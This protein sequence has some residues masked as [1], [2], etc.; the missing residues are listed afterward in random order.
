[1][2]LSV[3]VF[4]GIIIINSEIVIVITR[5]IGIARFVQYV[6]DPDGQVSTDRVGFQEVCALLPDGHS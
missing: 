2:L 4:A 3:G 1:M 5:A 6:R